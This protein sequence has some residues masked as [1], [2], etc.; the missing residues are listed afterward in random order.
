MR[1]QS[2]STSQ[3]GSA[4][5]AAPSSGQKLVMPGRLLGHP[6]ARPARRGRRSTRWVCASTRS[7]RS[8]LR[9]AA[10][11]AQQ[12]AL[13]IE[14]SA[15]LVRHPQRDVRAGRV[16]LGDDDRSGPERA[17]REGRGRDS[18]A[19]PSRTRTPRDP[20]AA[21]RPRSDRCTGRRTPLATGTRFGVAEQT[22]R[23]A[24]V[25]SPGA[26]RLSAT[27]PF[28]A[29]AVR[30]VLHCVGHD[31]VDDHALPGARA[32]HVAHHTRRPC[33]ARR[34]CRRWGRVRRS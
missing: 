14:H 20:S 10:A 12:A 2:A 29:A 9:P 16:T 6:R 33:P 23:A 15:V 13:G 30:I 21:T 18:R 22:G 32:L 3:P 28:A 34:C 1:P 11:R 19:T 8:P 24:Q 4:S 17:H 25:A 26:S 7:D 31:G 27:S 5:S